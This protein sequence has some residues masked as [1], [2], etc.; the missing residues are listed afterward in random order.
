MELECSQ[1]GLCEIMVRK[2]LPV[3]YQG[4][5]TEPETETEKN[6]I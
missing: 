2:K 5:F 3:F 1:S 6:Q 4:N